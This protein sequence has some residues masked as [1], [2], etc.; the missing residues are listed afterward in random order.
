MIHVD[1]GP[2]YVSGLLMKWAEKRR[3]AIEYI[4]PGKAQDQAKKW[5]WTYNN[6]RPNIAIGGEGGISKVYLRTL[7]YSTGKRGTF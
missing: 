6:H 4:Q 3:I 5:L 2:E 1:N 7:L